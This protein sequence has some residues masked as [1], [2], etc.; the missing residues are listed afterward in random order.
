[1]S[2]DQNRGNNN[3]ARREFEIQKIRELFIKM[4]ERL[5]N[6]A[7]LMQEFMPEEMIALTSHVRRIPVISSESILQERLIQKSGMGLFQQKRSIVCCRRNRR[8]QKVWLGPKLWDIPIWI[9]R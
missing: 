9:V 2:G 6:K 8:L 4:Y 7:A 1:M 5:D 3:S